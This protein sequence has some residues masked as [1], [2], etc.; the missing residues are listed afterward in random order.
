Y[1]WS[2]R[3]RRRPSPRRAVPSSA[4]LAGSGTGGTTNAEE[5]RVKLSGPSFEKL[6]VDSPATLT[7]LTKF[8]PQAALTA[9]AWVASSCSTNPTPPLPRIVPVSPKYR[10]PEAVPV[11]AAPL[12]NP[13]GV[14]L[15]LYP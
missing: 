6:I 9:A 11:H 2:R 1:T 4:K 5:N 3:R 8:A 12:R 14:R 7:Q 15:R 10:G 13:G